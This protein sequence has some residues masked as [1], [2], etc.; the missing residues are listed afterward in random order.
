M[1]ELLSCCSIMHISKCPAMKGADSEVIE[2]L[3][4]FLIFLL[5][6]IF[7]LELYIFGFD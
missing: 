2:F 7:H 5:D 1:F 6:N 4:N 3:N